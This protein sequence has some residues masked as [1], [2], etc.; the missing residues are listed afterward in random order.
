VGLELYRVQE[1]YRSTG[2]PVSIQ[3]APPR[4]SDVKLERG[5]N[6]TGIMKRKS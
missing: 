1:K 6:R 2:T 3:V 5:N 4:K